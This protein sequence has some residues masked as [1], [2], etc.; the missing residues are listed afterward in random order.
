[1]HW[2]LGVVAGAIM[3]TVAVPAVAQTDQTD[4][5]YSFTGPR[6]EIVGGWNHLLPDRET[7]GPV[8]STSQTP[9]HDGISA[10]VQG[11]YDM[12]VGP[13]VAGVFGGYALQTSNECGQLGGLNTGCLRPQAQAEGGARI[14]Y[15]YHGRFLAY[16]K[17]AYVNTRVQTTVLAGD[18]IMNSHL[19]KDGWRV[20][21][22]VE[23]AVTHHAYIKAEY[24]YTRTERFHTAPYGIDDTSVSYH[25][26]DVLAGFGVRF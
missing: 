23:Y 14:G 16:G 25:D 17:G 26:H 22:G 20:G 19:N 8:Y 15:Q 9:K 4:D 11:G 24:D 5:A 10:G 3:A 1:M 13:V 2:S 12:Q 21:G 7:S 18:R 6:V